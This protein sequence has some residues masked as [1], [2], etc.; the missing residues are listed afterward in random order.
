M[1][2]SDS[3]PFNGKATREIQTLLNKA[4]IQ[5]AKL[6]RKHAKRLG[7]AL[8]EMLRRSL[9]NKSDVD[10]LPARLRENSKPLH[11]ALLEMYTDASLLGVENGKTL[12]ERSI[13]LPDIKQMALDIDW[14]LANAAVLE[15]AA[16][17]SGIIFSELM[18]TSS[19][20]ARA[21]LILWI[22]S[23]APLKELQKTLSRPSMFG[24]SRGKLIAVT[25]TTRAYSQ[26]NMAAWRESGVVTGKEWQTARDDRV[27]EICA[28]LNGK[29]VELE[30][31]F[32]TSEGLSNVGEPPAHPGCRCDTAPI[33]RN[34]EERS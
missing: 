26:G 16:V 20:E 29:I 19:K 7:T 6:E 1:L 28:P 25:E 27:C 3:L 32:E 13:G 8:Q 18:A 23:G 15:W 12:V 34:F 30:G 17:E 11:E 14:S 10:N 9:R 31:Q 4:D 21:A 2:S 22:E 24:A 33:T 5:R